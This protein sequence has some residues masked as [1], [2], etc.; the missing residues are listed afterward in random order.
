MAGL[1]IREPRQ[2]HALASAVRLAMVDTLEGVGPCSVGELAGILGVAPDSL[3]YHLRILEKRGLVKRSGAV[4]DAV[5]ASVEL[6]YDATSAPNRRAIVR[7]AAA[8]V[9]AALRAF[10]TGFRPPVRTS[11]KRR[12]IWIAQRSARL[13]PAQ[14][15][16]VN[17]LLGELLH[18]LEESRENGPE[19]R[20]YLLTFALSP[21][22]KR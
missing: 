6:A 12:E 15:E 22:G 14:L 1:L 4:V 9:R 5:N 13:T 21:Y 17:H 20:L 18:T 7:V 2:I 16:H 19:E 11:G 8:I 3:Y 10:T